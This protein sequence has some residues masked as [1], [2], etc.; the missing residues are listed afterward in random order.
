PYD[1]TNPNNLLISKAGKIPARFSAGRR[2]VDGRPICQ[3]DGL[4]AGT[5]DTAFRNPLT[6]VPYL[7]R[8]I[9]DSEG[10]YEVDGPVWTKGVVWVDTDGVEHYRLAYNPDPEEY[11]GNTMKEPR[12]LADMGQKGFVMWARG[13]APIEVALIMPETAP[14]FDGGTCDLDGGEK[15]YDHLRVV[16]HLDDEWREYHAAWDDFSQE[17]WGKPV[18]LDPNRI[19]NVQIKVS[20]YKSGAKRD[21]DV[22]MDHI[23]FYGGETW[24]FTSELTAA[25]KGK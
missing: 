11:P 9:Y 21:F 19:I 12:C 22:W 2:T 15:C 6:R 7:N 1:P 10:L 18:A 13:D 16:F 24:T 8:D 3:D 25:N 5:V 14:N 20:G 4:F 17:G 23:G